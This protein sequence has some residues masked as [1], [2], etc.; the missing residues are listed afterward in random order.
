MTKKQRLARL[1]PLF[2]ILLILFIGNAINL[3]SRPTAVPTANATSQP[4]A[5]LAGTPISATAVPPTTPQSTPTPQPTSTLPP[6]AII[7]LQGPPERA[8]FFSGQTILFYWQWPAPLENNYQFTLY[9]ANANG[10]PVRQATLT[11]ANLGQSSYQVALQPTEAGE[12]RWWVVLETAVTTEAP[13][14]PLVTSESRTLTILPAPS[15]SQ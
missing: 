7:E 2:F 8:F 3:R 13:P 12:W 4:N 5:T 6:Q 15:P 10:E 11:E 14:T 9:T 1:S